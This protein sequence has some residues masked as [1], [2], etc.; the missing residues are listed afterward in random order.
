MNLASSDGTSVCAAMH[1]AAFAALGVPTRYMS[2][3]PMAPHVTPFILNESARGPIR[4]R[5]RGQNGHKSRM[6]SGL[7]AA[8]QRAGRD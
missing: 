1:V 3:K 4:N 8:R 2:Q 5:T 7:H 6:A